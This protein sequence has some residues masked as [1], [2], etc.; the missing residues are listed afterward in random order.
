M[1]NCNYIFPHGDVNVDCEARWGT[2][3]PSGGEKKW[4][5][6]LSLVKGDIFSYVT[7]GG[8]TQYWEV[9]TST[10]TTGV[11]PPTPV[12]KVALCVDVTLPSG[13]ESYLNT[14]INFAR[15]FCTVCLVER[16]PQL[17]Q[18]QAIAQTL[19]DIQFENGDNIEL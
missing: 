3:G 8:D 9:K 2:G 14:F 7:P 4:S 12:D 13:T 6:N 1:Y 19:N 11:T 10:Y 5:D 18:M 15:K 16:T 17:R